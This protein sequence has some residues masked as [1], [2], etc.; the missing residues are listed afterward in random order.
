[1]KAS[2]I[3]DEPGPSYRNMLRAGFEPT[4]VRPVYTPPG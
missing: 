1:M 3:A 4:Y 2:E